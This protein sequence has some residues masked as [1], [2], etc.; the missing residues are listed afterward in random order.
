MAR[1]GGWPPTGFGGR[2]KQLREERSLTQ[3]ELAARSGCH[4][5]TIAKLERGAQEPAWPL[6]LA[7]AKALGVTC[8]AFSGEAAALPAEQRPRGRPPKATAEPVEAPQPKRPRGR[9]RKGT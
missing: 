9:P 3:H 4:T 7:L 5:M 2:L 1:H 8:E 6:V